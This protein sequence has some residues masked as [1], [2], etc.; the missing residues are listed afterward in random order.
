M[1]IK[2][3]RAFVVLIVFVQ[4]ILWCGVRGA[5]ALDEA[6]ACNFTF[7]DSAE[8]YY[9]KED[10]VVHARVAE[11]I[12]QTLAVFYDESN[13]VWS[14]SPED[15]Q[16][17]ALKNIMAVEGTLIY[18]S[19]LAFEPGI[20]T[21][22]VGLQD[23]VP[24]PAATDDQLSFDAEFSNNR[25]STLKTYESNTP[26]YCPYAYHGEP[27]VT[28]YE[29]CSKTTPEF[30]PTMDLSRAYDYSDV[31]DPGV[32]WYTAPR[33]LF[34]RDNIETGYWTAPYYDEGAGKINMVTYSQPI[35]RK[36]K[37]LGVATIDIEVDAL[38]YGNQCTSSCPV[39]DY[40]FTISACATDNLRHI[41]YTSERKDCNVADN[42]IDT[43]P[44]SW[45]PVGSTMAIFAI[46][47]GCIGGVI[48]LAVLIVLIVKR[49]HPLIKASQVNICYGY[50]AGAMFANL[51][52]FTLVGEYTNATCNIKFW[53]L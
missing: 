6:S 33:C 19:A 21:S 29:N 20:W 37:F 47:L 31:S 40:N 23:G 30:C 11:I 24:F 4:Q 28:A 36:G 25:I 51:G 15:L 38:C 53:F 10:F 1:Q 39:E 26:V 3:A 34:Y 49:K 12:G 48:N 44:C 2:V 27:N 7:T 8:K 52:T 35:V 22:V 50:V 45:V 13:N 14:I 46:T 41:V 5:R 32:E 18:G 17:I 16:E 42:A 43:L 9:G